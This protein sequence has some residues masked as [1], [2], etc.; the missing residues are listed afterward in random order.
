LTQNSVLSLDHPHPP[1]LIPE[2]VQYE[3][4]VL[5]LL[6]ITYCL[7]VKRLKVTELTKGIDGLIDIIRPPLQKVP[8]LGPAGRGLLESRTGLTVGGQLPL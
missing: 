8:L 6:E 1:L 4:A 3:Q 7:L 2:L 5:Q